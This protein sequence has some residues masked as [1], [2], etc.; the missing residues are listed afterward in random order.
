MKRTITVS[1]LIFLLSFSALALD[2][3]TMFGKP[4]EKLSRD[5]RR[6]FWRKRTLMEY[7][8]DGNPTMENLDRY[9]DVFKDRTVFDDKV[10]VFD[11]NAENKAGTITLTGEVLFPNHKAG[12]ERVLNTLGFE[13]IEN[14]IRILPNKESLGEKGFAIV[15]EDVLSMTKNPREFSEQVNQLLKDFPVRLL[16]PD[17]TGKYF[18]IQGPDAYIGWVYSEGINRMPLKEWADFRKVRKDD[19]EARKKILEICKPIMGVEYVW[20]GISEKGLDC[21]G[22]TQYVYRKFDVALPRDADEQSNVG[23]LVGFPGYRHNLRPGDLLFFC[24]STG[25]IGHV[26]LSLGGDL[27]LQ[28]KGRDGVHMSSFDP[29]SPIYDESGDERFI[30]ARR[31]LMDEFK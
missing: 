11:V 2:P 13:K 14:K 17:E 30:L 7:E 22:F 31:I 19:T 18:L 6:E 29:E 16:K 28:S 21:S 25:R 23:A 24:S 1:I 10:L 15:T 8:P 5:Q 20:G 3:V 4:W 9:I 12:V 26:G 27:F